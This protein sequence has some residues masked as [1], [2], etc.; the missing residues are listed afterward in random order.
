VGFKEFQEIIDLSK[1]NLTI[2]K[3]FSVEREICGSDTLEKLVLALVKDFQELQALYFA[4]KA[5][6]EKIADKA[7]R[8]RQGNV[9][10]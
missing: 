2:Q 1:E 5:N 4:E 6:S 7:N 8:R 10:S 9:Q 3:F